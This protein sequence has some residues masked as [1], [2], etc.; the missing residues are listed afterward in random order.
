MLHAVPWEAG[1]AVGTIVLA[2]VNIL[3]V[4]YL[5]KQT[6]IAAQTAKSAADAADVAKETLRQDHYRRR[7]QSTL[8]YWTT[9]RQVYYRNYASLMSVNPA[10]NSPERLEV[11]EYLGM[12]EAFAIGIN[13]DLFDF[14]V[15]SD[16]SGGFILRI[17]QRFETYI[18]A[19]H[20]RTDGRAYRDLLKLRARLIT[21]YEQQGNAPELR[22]LAQP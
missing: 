18:E 10:G 9:T 19:Q 5:V 16:L 8:E 15:A 17:C 12:L 1:T 11:R 14:D 21:K 6:K 20:N 13:T 22:Q 4:I 3:V 7:R 2:F